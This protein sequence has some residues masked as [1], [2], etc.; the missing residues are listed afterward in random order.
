LRN[1]CAHYR[2]PQG[3]TPQAVRAAEA[4]N[5]A[6]HAAGELGVPVIYFHGIARGQYRPVAPVFVIR[7]DPVRRLVELQ[8]ALPVAD[9]TEAGLISNEDVGPDGLVQHVAL[10]G[11]STSSSRRRSVGASIT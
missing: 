11:A 9:L 10:G 1:R 3:D 7:D 8:A 4:D 5:R 6:L 2:A